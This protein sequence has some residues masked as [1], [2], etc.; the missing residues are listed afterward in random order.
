MIAFFQSSGTVR[1]YQAFWIIVVIHFKP[2]APHA[3]TTSIV[4]SSIPAAFLL[5]LVLMA[6]STS[7]VK[8]SG[9]RCSECEG[10]EF[11]VI[12]ATPSEFKRFLK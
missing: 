12:S 10:V 2:T 7:V 1:S 6:L 5:E 9:S 3:F 8:I 4:I 11:D